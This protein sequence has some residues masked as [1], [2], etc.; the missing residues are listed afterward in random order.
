MGACARFIDMDLQLITQELL[1]A[2]GGDAGAYTRRQIELLASNGRPERMETDVIGKS[3]M[4]SDAKEFVE[5][6]GSIAP[7]KEKD[8]NPIVLVRRLKTHVTSIFMCSN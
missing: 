8:I 3:I 6:G 1:D 2:G 5:L 7:V 4:T